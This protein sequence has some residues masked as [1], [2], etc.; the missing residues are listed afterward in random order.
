[1]K[2]AVTTANGEV[3]QHFGHTPGFT[4]FEVTNGHITGE[5]ELLS[6]DSGHGALATLLAAEKVDLLICGGIGGGAVN[7]LAAAGIEVVGGAQGNVREAAE[8]FLA[9]TLIVRKDFHCN[10]HHHAESHSCG[11]H[12]CG[13]GN[14]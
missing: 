9:G 1:M 7:A 8:N 12:K 11:E 4:V 10:H 13:S 2:I 14:C 3:F 6:G 5:K